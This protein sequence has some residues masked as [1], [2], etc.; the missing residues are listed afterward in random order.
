MRV[1][2]TRLFERRTVQF[3]EPIAALPSREACR[4]CVAREG[5]RLVFSRAS[6][7]ASCGTLELRLRLWIQGLNRCDEGRWGDPKMG[8]LT[9]GTLKLTLSSPSEVPVFSI[10]A[11]PCVSAHGIRKRKGVRHSARLSVPSMSL[12]SISTFCEGHAGLRSS[13]G[14]KLAA[15]AWKYICRRSGHVGLTGKHNVSHV[16][17]LAEPPVDAWHMQALQLRTPIASLPLE[18]VGLQSQ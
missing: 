17:D 16:L 6:G 9:Q 8:V 5:F 2:C 10:G 18:P 15:S 14:V 12:A 7:A 4:L 1:R 13:A 3:A 11:R